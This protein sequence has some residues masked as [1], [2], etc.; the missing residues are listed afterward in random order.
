MGAPDTTHYDLVIIGGGLAGASLAVALKH[1]LAAVQAS[2][3][4]SHELSEPYRIAVVEAFA[5]DDGQ[6]PSYDDRSIA[7]SW[8]SRLIYQHIGVWSAIAP[9]AEPI[10]TIHISDRGHFGVTRLTAEQEGVEALGYVV[11]NRPVGMALF[12]EMSE[13]DE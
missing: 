7:L 10:E 2:G 4:S 5:P 6:Q 8:G 3:R 11:E 12:R 13:G 1:Q 9:H